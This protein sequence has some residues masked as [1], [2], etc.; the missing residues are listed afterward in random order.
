MV[1]SPNSNLGWNGLINGEKALSGVYV[2][3]IEVVSDDGEI[4]KFSGDITL[5]R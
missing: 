2:Y 1:N 3:Y 5:I 4:T